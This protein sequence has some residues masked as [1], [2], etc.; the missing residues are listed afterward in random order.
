MSIGSNIL[1]LRQTFGDGLTVYRYRNRLRPRIL[2]TPAISGIG[3]DSQ[4][5][6]HV[7]TRA[8]DWL[9]LVWTLKSFYLVTGRRYGLCVHD[10]GTMGEDGRDALEAHFPGLRYIPAA[11][12]DAET[13]EAL[14][15]YPRT[16]AF[17]KDFKL[18]RKVVDFR[19][20]LRGERMLLLDSDV[21]FFEHPVEL[22]RRIEDPAYRKNSLNADI[23]TS[24]T[25]EAATVKAELGIE[26]VER[27]NSGLGLIHRASMDFEHV[28]RLLA[29]PGILGHFWRIEQTVYALASML[30]G[31]EMLPPEYDVYRGEG[32][33]DRPSRHYVGEI[34]NLMYTE[35]MRR[36]RKQ[37]TVQL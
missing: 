12:S 31:Y 18:A 1:Y 15:A 17:R 28:E 26:M 24:Y 34:R 33:G 19:H 32:L 11:R 29:I 21:L 13:A 25:V 30:H 3:R 27:I 23:S 8:D 36:L 35:G 6:I 10:D 20:Y 2:D 4:A 5:E 16:L 7:L 9:N 14:A 22:L 37:G